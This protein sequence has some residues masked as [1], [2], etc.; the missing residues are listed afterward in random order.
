MKCGCFSCFKTD[1]NCE[2]FHFKFP[3]CCFITEKLKITN[4]NNKPTY[5]NTKKNTTKLK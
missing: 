2:T 1:E 4:K 3:L 5:C